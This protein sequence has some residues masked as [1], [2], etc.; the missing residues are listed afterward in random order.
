MDFETK[1]FWVMIGLCI[2]QGI[3]MFAGYTEFEI[4]FTRILVVAGAW[5]GLDTASKFAKPKGDK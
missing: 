2:I 5:G 1:K 3:G 4:G